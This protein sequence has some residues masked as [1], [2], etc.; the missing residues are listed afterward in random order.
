MIIELAT[1]QLYPP[2]APRRT[3]LWLPQTTLQLICI[4]L[5]GYT[6]N[7]CSSHRPWI[8]TPWIWRIWESLTDFIYNVWRCST[9]QSMDT[10]LPF[11]CFVKAVAISWSVTQKSST[12]HKAE[13]VN[14]RREFGDTKGSLLLCA[15]CLE[16]RRKVQALS[17]GK[18][19]TCRF[20]TAGSFCGTCLKQTALWE[21]VLVGTRHS[22]CLTSNSTPVQFVKTIFIGG[23]SYHLKTFYQLTSV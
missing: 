17:I 21:A 2:A 18:M 13:L 11:D 10:A 14:V 23:P 22:I 12:L 15:W 9:D 16:W 8:Y 20:R 3:R 7:M 4:M 19:W 1:A 5:Y 6:E